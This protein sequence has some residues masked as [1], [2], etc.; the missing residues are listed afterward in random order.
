MRLF[1]G[2]GLGLSMLISVIQACNI[3]LMQYNVEWLFIDYYAP[4]DCPGNGCNWH[5]TD[6]AETHLDMVA[7]VIQTLNPDIVN[8]CEVEGIHELSLLQEVLNDTTYTPYLI[9]GTDTS[10]G[11]NVALFTRIDPSVPLRRVET[12]YPYPLPNSQCGYT[13]FGGTTGVSKHYITEFQ[14]WKPVAMISA[15]L[16]AYPTDPTRCAER[17]AQA[18]ILQSVVAEYI[19]NGYEVILL[20]DFNDFD[21]E[22][23][24]A[25][26]NVPTSRTLDILKG[27]YEGSDDLYHLINVAEQIP[28][29]ERYTEWWDSEGD[30]GIGEYSM[31]DHILV[32][33]SL[34]SHITNAFIYHGYAEYCDTMNSDHYPVVIDLVY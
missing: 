11:Q 25:Y 23:R 14:L 27:D 31:I 26:D 1:F 2:L 8:L 12:K 13:G 29:D 22:V 15:H 7:D 9:Q 4:M 32:T 6:E 30:C 16:L 20:G 33:E 24:D 34:L 21:N 19:S 28:K 10:T 18:Y 3:R 17:E 5:N